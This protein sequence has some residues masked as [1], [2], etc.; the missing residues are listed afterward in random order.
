MQ[1]IPAIDL[2]DGQ[3]VRLYQGDFDQQTD[4]SDD[5]ASVVREYESMGFDTLH[6]VDLDGAL[7]GQPKN[8]DIILDILQSTN[9]AVQLGGGLRTGARV[10]YWFDAGLAR[11]VIGSLA[12]T[13]PETVRDWMTQ[14]GADRIVL[15][16]D[17][18]VS[19]TGVPLLATHGWRQAGSV[20]LFQCIDDFATAGLQH[21]LC[22]DI[23]KDG[24][25][26]GPNLELYAELLER[27]P[28]IQFQASGGV[29]DIADLQALRE[30]GAQAAITGRA[31]LEGNITAEEISAF[32]PAA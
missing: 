31:L 24:A 23:S 4:Y 32:L 25:L 11:A 9:M 12:V 28:E 6:I 26:S 10:E 18:N 19:S 3:C 1:V 27:Y 17:I 5:P 22:T 8:Q 2:R 13:K 15:A 20:S 21:V 16:L 29:R 30:M 14:Y 7:T